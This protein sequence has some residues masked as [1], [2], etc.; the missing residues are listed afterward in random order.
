MKELY[1]LIF[2]SFFSIQLISQP[3]LRIEP[4]SWWVGMKNSELQLMVYGEDIGSMVPS[5]KATDVFLDY[6]MKVENDNYLFI[7]LKIEKTAQAQAVDI[8]FTSPSGKIIKQS[9]RL[10]DR[11]PDSEVRQGFDASD[12]IYLITP[13]RFCNGDESNDNHSEFQDKINRKDPYGRH[14][15][16]LAGIIAKLDYVTDMG[17][18]A[19]W[20]NPVLENKQSEQSYHGYAT[21]D[22]YKVDPR[23]GT[24]DLY[25]EMVAEAQKRGIK[26][27]MDMI[28]NH[29]GSGHWWIKDLP[30]RDW[31][32][33]QDKYQVTNHRRTTHIDPYASLEEGEDM[34]R[35]WFV[36]S[37]PDL[38][39]TNP[40]LA[41]YIIQNSIWWIEY[42]GLAG[43]RQDTYP[44]P[45]KSFMADWSCAIMEEYPY[46]NIVGEEWTENPVLVAQW[47]QDQH[48]TEDY[49]T[50]LPSL[51]DFPLNMKVSKALVDK[52]AWNS[53]LITLYEHMVNDVLYANPY[54]LVIFPDNHDMSRIF[55]QLNEDFGLYKSA[56]VYFLTMRG[57]PQIFYGTEI[58]MGNKG[59]DS[60]G[61]IRSD[62]P[63]G[64]KG[65]KVDA[66]DGLGISKEVIVARDF[67]KLL[68]NWRRQSFAV[69][70]GKLTHYVPENGMYVYFRYLNNDVVMIVINKNK[71]NTTL[72]L[73]RFS[74]F[75]QG[76]INAFDVLNDTN[77]QLDKVI[78]VPSN[79]PLIL[80]WTR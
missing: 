4:P 76:S 37:M 24:N 67:N 1:V 48:I 72:D 68:N 57:I 5:I 33:Y 50:C 25:R 6:Y 31:I 8:A 40:F 27:I 42:A 38:N 23:F 66:F 64:W 70:Y 28:A 35:G 47:Q 16:D 21:T 36:P 60:H 74:R 29:C 44:Y 17:Y 41:T 14:G 19:I 55:T 12:I 7:N 73:S 34:V 58:L 43:I 13:D 77:I 69:Q 15:G 53:G 10:D 32:N 52:E 9:F 39:Q 75:I 30:M 22:Y 71:E 2:L 78:E 26:V 63:G 56:M 62:F 45:D 3:N 20:L 59:T 79:S 46:L 51:M 65:D 61:V 80:E 54:N 11:I 49:P 18:S